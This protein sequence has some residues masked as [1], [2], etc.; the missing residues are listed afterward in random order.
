MLGHPIYH[1]CDGVAFYYD[2]EPVKGEIMQ[3]ERAIYHDGSRP[4][5]HSAVICGS[6][7]EHVRMS[8]GIAI[9]LRWG[10]KADR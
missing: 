1:S 5:A 8:D 7:H 9:G 6:C 3:A 2:S 10:S 4:N